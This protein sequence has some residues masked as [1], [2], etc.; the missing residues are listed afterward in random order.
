MELSDISD[1]A[2]GIVKTTPTPKVLF[3]SAFPLKKS[4]TSPSYTVPKDIA[5]AESITLPPPTASINPILF[6]LQIFIPS[7]TNESFGFGTTP[8][9]SINSIPYFLK[10]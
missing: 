8:P 6:S 2:P 3:G 5:L 1:P 9:N 4:Q 7:Y 10:D